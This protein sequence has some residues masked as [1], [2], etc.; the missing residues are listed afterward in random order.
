M[1]NKKKIK[2][3]SFKNRKRNFSKSKLLKKKKKNTKSL[4]KMISFLIVSFILI[5]TL[6][7]F[8]L[9]KKYI[10]PLPPV[11]NIKNL[12][13]AQTS[14]IYDKDW[15]ELYKIYKENRTYIDYKDISKNMINALV[16]WEDQR[17]WTTPGFDLIWIS[18]AA[19]YGIFTGD[20][21]WT[22]G[23]SQQL[24]KVTY[25][26]NERS[27]ERKIKE[28]Y[29]SWKLNKVYDK[30]KILELYLNKIF[31]GSNAYWIEQA[32]KTFFW[33][34]AKDLNILQSSVLASLPKAPSGLS[35]Y[36][37]KPKLMGYPLVYSKEDEENKTKLL[38]KKD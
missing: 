13:I 32:S 38:T 23:L 18:R 37:K 14:T 20:F 22:S 16:A 31:F 30:T 36:S 4:F 9:Y 10:E 34:S 15:G 21:K 26:T 28:F 5:W 7:G 35:P 29:L 2:K 12:N 24:M 3:S 6:V 11:E 27:I 8:I 25:L 17:F 19:I 1:F 33:I